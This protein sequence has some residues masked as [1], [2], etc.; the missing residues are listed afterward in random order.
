ML[1][2]I[3]HDGGKNERTCLSNIFFDK[4]KF[5]DDKASPISTGRPKISS[6]L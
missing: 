3:S 4:G 2:F 5:S 1:L 6:L